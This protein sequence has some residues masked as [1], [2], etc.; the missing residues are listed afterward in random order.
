[1]KSVGEVMAI[2]RTFEECF[3]KAI[4]MTDSSI[5]GFGHLG[6]FANMSEAEVVEE[7]TN[8]TDRWLFLSVSLLCPSLFLSFFIIIY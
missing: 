1:M 6:A 8:P 4:R 7:L 2:G 3:S 5:D